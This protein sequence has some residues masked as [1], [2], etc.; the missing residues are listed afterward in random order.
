MLQQGMVIEDEFSEYI[1]L[2]IAQCPLGFS[3][4]DSYL[5]TATRGLNPS[6]PASQ[7]Q[8]HG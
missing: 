7:T 1:D 2:L 5:V 6:P 8:Q 3:D 4:L